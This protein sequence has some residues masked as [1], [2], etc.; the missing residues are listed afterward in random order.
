MLE[1]DPA[2]D[3]RTTDPDTSRQAA[4]DQQNNS[5]ANRR[6]ALRFYYESDREDGWAAFE[7]E[8]AVPEGY[9]GSCYWKRL[10]ELRD[11]GYIAEVGR[12]TN[13]AT[14]QPQIVNRITGLGCEELGYPMLDGL[15][16]PQ[17]RERK[18]YTREQFADEL[19][20]P[21]SELCDCARRYSTPIGPDGSVMAHHCECIAV[22]ASQ[23]VRKGR[24]LTL[25]ERVCGCRNR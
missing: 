10:S 18:H 17:V 13:P 2:R 12:R 4:Y 14:K 15:P 1:R 23:V 24:S 8:A 5:R 3:V 16:R 21:Y 19:E 22:V 20:D 11:M 6:K 7:F 25:H 9:A